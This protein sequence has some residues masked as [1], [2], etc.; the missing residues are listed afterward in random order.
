MILIEGIKIFDNAIF[1]LNLYD[2]IEINDG[3]E[4]AKGYDIYKN[5]CYKRNAFKPKNT[6][7]K[8]T[9]EEMQVITSDTSLLPQNKII[10]VLPIP[11]KIKSD[12]IKKRFHDVK[13]S[14]EFSKLLTD[15][16]NELQILNKSI[17]LFLISILQPNRTIAEVELL[18]FS[19][20]LPKLETI[21]FTPKNKN[22]LGLHLDNS[23]AN[24]I[25]NRDNSPNRISIN[26]GKED[27]YLLF[28][29]LSISQM[30]NMIL[31][32]KK[33]FLISTKNITESDL[34][35]TF[36]KYYSNYPILRL[37]QKPYESYVAPTDNIIHDGSTIDKKEFDMTVV[38]IGYFKVSAN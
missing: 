1:S 4:V 37:K 14:Y 23:S 6:W 7:R 11:K 5:K 20:E 33:D 22:Y 8:L 15:K 30:L 31:D 19:F 27:R 2:R 26:I 12:F 24:S 28:V 10:G 17:A 35:F 9:L 18:A 38:F 25:F 21:A 3:V 34:V 29:N 13:N 16:A 36:F 32:K